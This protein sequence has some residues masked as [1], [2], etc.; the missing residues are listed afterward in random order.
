M[1]SLLLLLAGMS[2]VVG[3]ILVFRVHAFF[4]LVLGAYCVALL[5][6]APALHSYAGQRVA[7]GEFTA[8]TAAKFPEKT[9]AARVADEF[10]KT[11]ANLGILIGM[12]AILGEAMMLSGAAETIAAAL[13]RLMGPKRAHWAFFTTA[14]LL[15]IP[16]MLL[17]APLLKAI[18][19][20]MKRDY[21]LLVMCTVA[22]GT[23]THSLVPP[24][25]GPLFVA[26]DLGVPLGLM[27]GM[28][29]AIGLGAALAG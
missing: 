20:R 9:A 7:K 2:L 22:S 14:Y 28:G 5:T 25:P 10:G 12:A 8:K 1:Y 4:A 11:C 23:I 21:L 24:T 15:C 6:P 16:V 17:C 18:G 19:R 27:I 3:G 13:L 29:S 26:G